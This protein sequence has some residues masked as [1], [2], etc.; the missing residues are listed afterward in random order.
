MKRIRLNAKQKRLVEDNLPVVAFVVNHV[1][2]TTF[3]ASLGFDEAKSVATLEL[4]KRARTF[5]PAKGL[6]FGTYA[7]Q[8]IGSALRDAAVRRQRQMPRGGETP[9]EVL[10]APARGLSPDL[11]AVAREEF[12]LSGVSGQPA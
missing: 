1:R 4:V 9:Y 11:E 7:F 6:R 12:A 10:A 3:S 5:K 2:Y 8:A